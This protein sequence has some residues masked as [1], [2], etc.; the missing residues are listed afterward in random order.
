M[1]VKPPDWSGKTVFVI[2]SGPSLTFGDCELVRMTGCPVIVTNTTFR[3]CPWAEALFAFDVK[4][5]DEYHEEVKRVF[6]GRMLTYSNT[7]M[8]YGAESLFDCSWFT[9][10]SNSGACAISIAIAAKAKRI[11]LL[12]A[13]CQK[14]GGETHWHGDHPKAMRSERARKAW[15]DG[16]SNAG[17]MKKWPAQ[18]KA[19]AMQAEIHGVELLNAS[20]ETALDC[21][22][23]VALEDVI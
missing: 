5:W 13:D 23:R 17:S 12:G 20:R 18:Y 15:P 8:R 6:K 9:S 11:V 4:W 19:A 2:A 10:H 1:K 3:M 16:M 7:A 22:R 14:T 21:I